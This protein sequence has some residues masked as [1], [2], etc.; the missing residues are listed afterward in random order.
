MAI[1]AEELYS[2][3]VPLRASR[4]IV[5]RSCVGEVIRYTPATAEEHPDHWLR[6]KT[7]WNSLDIPVVSFEA[8]CG[9]EP[10]PPSRRT[11]IVV[12]H[13]LSESPNC[14]PY[15]ILAEGFPQMVKVNREVIVLDD[16]Y[17]VAADAPVIC[18]IS[19]LKEHALIPDLE[20]VEQR[21]V[22]ELQASATASA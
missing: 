16:A 10:P 1:I 7:R 22:A 3:L 20:A 9:E 2:L 18:Q 8:L 19:M 5:P 6:G 17:R 11:R 15:G 12:F 21:L 4:L 13:P 14:P